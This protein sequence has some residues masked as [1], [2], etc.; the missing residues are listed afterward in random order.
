MIIMATSRKI[1]ASSLAAGKSK[2]EES[3]TIQS[4]GFN[5]VVEGKEISSVQS[6]WWDQTSFNRGGK[7]VGTEKE[8]SQGREGFPGNTS[9][10]LERKRSTTVSIWLSTGDVHVKC[11]TLL[12]SYALNVP[13][14]R[15]G[16]AASTADF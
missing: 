7:V 5:A 3:L 10:V 1:S 15:L 4:K 9:K 11:R 13:Y 8:K 14:K 16:K 12:H 6:L 2:E